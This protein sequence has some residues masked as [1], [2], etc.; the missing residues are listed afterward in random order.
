MALRQQAARLTIAS[1]DFSNILNS[2]NKFTTKHLNCQQ[3]NPPKSVFFCIFFSDAENR[4][5]CPKNTL[6][7]PRLGL[8]FSPYRRKKSG[9]HQLPTNF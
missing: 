6:F 2:V 4:P 7:R 9:P 3:K 1:I 8:T 5:L